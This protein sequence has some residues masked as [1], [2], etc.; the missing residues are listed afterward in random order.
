MNILSLYIKDVFEILSQNQRSKLLFFTFL[1][2]IGTLLETIGVGFI[3]PVIEAISNYDRFILRLK[4]L[5][6]DSL[7]ELEQDKIILL[8]IGLL[9]L[10]YTI[11]N[12]FLTLLSYLQ[13]KFLKEIKS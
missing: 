2:L 10:I 6:L 9:L 1:F 3:I 5:N 4:D 12:L 7:Y 11:K 8:V 13:F